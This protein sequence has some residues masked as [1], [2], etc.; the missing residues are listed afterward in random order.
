M[1]DE[2][3][4]TPSLFTHIDV[5]TASTSSSNADN[6]SV[7][8]LL[9]QLVHAQTRQNE[10]IEQLIQQMNAAQRQRSSEL[11]QW[12]QANP[13]LAERCRDAAETLGQVQTQFLENVTEQIEENAECMMDGEFMMNEFVDRFGPRLAHLNGVL[14]VLSQLGSA[15]PSSNNS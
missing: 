14:Q 8:G 2:S 5:T 7:N 12:K 3:R 13:R 9:S 1:S 6:S 10:L 15:P 4:P 11:G